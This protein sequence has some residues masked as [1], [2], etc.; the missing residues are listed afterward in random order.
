MVNMDSESSLSSLLSSLQKT[1][2]TLPESQILTESEP[3]LEPQIP[4]TPY[5]KACDT[6]RDL[7][8]QIL[9]NL[10]NHL[11]NQANST[12]NTA[13]NSGKICGVL[14]IKQGGV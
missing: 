9:K 14:G 12:H 6:D 3:E 13:G 4:H 10:K 2:D 11:K 7:R 5:Q 8:L 1:C